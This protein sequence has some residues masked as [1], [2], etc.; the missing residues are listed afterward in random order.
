MASEET[1]AM[2]RNMAMALGN[3]Q[4]VLSKPGIMIPMGIVCD[5]NQAFDQL[6]VAEAG[7]NAWLLTDRK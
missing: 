6:A 3:L 7:F 2:I 4:R 5:L 1:T